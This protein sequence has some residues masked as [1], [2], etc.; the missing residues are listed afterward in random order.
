M[1]YLVPVSELGINRRVSM[2][3]WKSLPAWDAY[4]G[5]VN[6]RLSEGSHGDLSRWI[7]ALSQLP[8]IDIEAVNLGEQVQVLGEPTPEANKQ[9]QDALMEFHP[10][11]KGPIDLFNTYINTEWRS[12]WKWQR[13]K[14]H[15]DSLNGRNILDVGCGNGYFGWRLL[16][17]GAQKV[18]GIDPTILFVMQHFVLQ[19]Y[20]KDPR[21]QVLPLRLEELEG[22]VELF[23]TVLSLGVIYHRKQPREHIEELMN[24]LR[25]GGQLVIES[26]YSTLAHDIIPNDR[27]A[28]MH[29]VWCLPTSETLVSWMQDAGLVDVAVV[30]I[31]T[32]SIEEQR[33][34]DW[35]QF[36]SLIH[37]LDPADTT[38]TVE[39]YPAPVRI[40]ATARKAD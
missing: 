18:T 1:Y 36:E 2:I 39:G 13:L 7:K 32:T 20:L 31:T 28:R 23:D 40:I 19:T 17:A 29:N 4:Q 37:T 27:Y 35:M 21:H 3:D 34:T 38:K 12:D 9:L 11:R 8:K 14:P 10:W 25:P 33:P 16:G 30:D 22:T 15:L 24:Q 26:L 6:A 5:K